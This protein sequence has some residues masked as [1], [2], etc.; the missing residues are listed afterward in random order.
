[1]KW[2]DPTIRL[3]GVLMESM[4]TYAL[5]AF[6]VAALTD[7]GK[8]SFLGVVAL[9][10]VSYALSR[11]LQGTDL[12]LGLLRAWGTAASLLLFYAIVRVDFFGDWR[13][14]DF[15]WANDL[16]N[17]TTSTVDSHTQAAF[18]V[19]LV[20]VFWM[21]GILRGQETT[22]FEDVA[23]SFGIGILIV[24]FVELFQGTVDDSPAMVGRVAVPYVAFGL[25]AVGLAHSARAEADRSRPFGRTFL[26]AVGVSVGALA[27]AAAIVGLFDL[28]T[29]LD[30]AR[31]AATSAGNAA[32]AVGKVVAWP[33]MQIADGFFKALIWLR[34]AVL[35][36]PQPPV[37]NQG[38]QQQVPDCVQNLVSQG[39]SMA[40]AMKACNPTPKSLPEWVHTLIRVMVAV[41]AVGA[42]VLMVALLFARFRKRKPQGELK[43]SSYQQGRLAADLSELL[44]DLVGRLRPSIHIR[45]DHQ[46]AVRRLYFEVL[47]EGERH[48]VMRRPAQTP[49][50][51]APAL[52][53]RFGGPAPREITGAFDEAR[54]GGR[55]APEAEV[56]RLRQDWEALR[57]G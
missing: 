31:S 51:H 1:M 28:V 38:D 14:W 4:W 19:P 21:R 32:E 26:M 13:F 46:D 6:A 27:A 8:P 42:V 49:D 23:T 44:Q 22:T 41:P 45:R 35:G 18:G 48:G 25:F 33:L 29:G 10:V 54:Y 15:G 50:E 5:V 3:T 24:A 37:P 36:K 16:F 39:K 43:E 17:R 9:V 2:R 20:A 47:E 57:R 34:D 55:V 12:S 40:D 30:A 11:G 7:G 56:R 52:E 53:S